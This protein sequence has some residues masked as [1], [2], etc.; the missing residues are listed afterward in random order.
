VTARDWTAPTSFQAGWRPALLRF[1]LVY[2][3]LISP[4]AAGTPRAVAS[5]IQARAA[6]GAW[7]SILE[8]RHFDA[9][10]DRALLRY[11]DAATDEVFIVPRRLRHAMWTATGLYYVLQLRPASR[12][13]ETNPGV[14]TRAEVQ[15]E[16][17]VSLAQCRWVIVC[18]YG[19]WYE[20][21]GTQ[22]PGAPLLVD[23]IHTQYAPVYHNFDF[24]LLRRSTLRH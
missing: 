3:A 6:N 14:E 13:V 10:M 4:F 18:R 24:T 21:S 5:E 15:R 12:H 22:N 17:I 8:A 9:R 11:I 23:H 19:Y 16:I 7:H 20:P 1:V 2:S